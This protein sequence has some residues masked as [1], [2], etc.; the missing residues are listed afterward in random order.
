MPSG[1]LWE[2]VDETAADRARP[3]G[4]GLGATGL[5]SGLVAAPPANKPV[6]LDEAAGADEGVKPTYPPRACTPPAKVPQSP[7]DPVPSGAPL[8]LDVVLPGIAPEEVLT[9]AAPAEPVVVPEGRAGAVGE[10][11]ATGIVPTGIAL[12]GRGDEGRGL[13]GMLG[14]PPSE[15]ISRLEE[16]LAGAS[17]TGRLSAATAGNS[18]VP[19]TG[20]TGKAV[21]GRA[22]PSPGIHEPSAG[23]VAGAPPVREDELAGLPAPALDRELPPDGKLPP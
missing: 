11:G 13:R 15:G 19:N 12:A 2:D 3:C 8:A 10:P 5:S 4:A 18:S 14:R 20:S 6:L 17:A 23:L 22:G 9:G 21:S 1:G 7:P 16:V